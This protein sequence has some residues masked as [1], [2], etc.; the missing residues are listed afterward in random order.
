M[1]SGRV[2]NG[3]GNK[4]NL[5]LK[6]ERLPWTA[7]DEEVLRREWNSDVPVHTIAQRLNRTTPSVLK[8]AKTLELS[9][10]KTVSISER[11]RD[12]ELRQAFTEWY[13]SDVPIQEVATRL[14]TSISLVY[15]AADL[16][17]LPRRNKKY[18]VP[19]LRK[20]NRKHSTETIQ[21]IREMRQ[22]KT[23]IGIIANHLGMTYGAIRSICSRE[24]IRTGA[25]EW[26]QEQQDTLT[27]LLAKRASLEEICQALDRTPRSVAWRMCKTGLRAKYPYVE[28]ALTALENERPRTLKDV[29]SQR[30]VAAK[31]RRAQND[32][33]VCDI[34]LED[35]LRQ[36]EDQRGL[37]YYSGT[38]LS[39]RP[40]D[41]N[42]LSL[43]RVDSEKGYV[44]GNVVLCGAIVNKMKTDLSVEQFIEICTAIA[45]HAKRPI[46]TPPVS[47]LA[48][49]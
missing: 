5:P 32:K 31:S 34:T 49:H 20:K 3:R 45:V 48:A 44:K 10:R 26:S 9:N 17:G 39:L 37:C 6:A 40:N 42:G 36:F 35:L 7:Q 29:L 24:G 21:K 4:M 1:E 16:I 25:R 11:L 23:P 2:E 22:N 13:Q 46:T 33:K 12:N 43:D 14:G 27:S 41:I 18:A 30:L 38:S 28:T 8:R 15:K 47:A 19:V